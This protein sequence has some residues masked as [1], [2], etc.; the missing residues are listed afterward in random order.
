M[1]AIKGYNLSHGTH[2]PDMKYLS[3][4]QPIETLPAPPMVV[5]SLS[6]SLGKPS[7]PAVEPGYRVLQGQLI[8]S[9]NGDISSNIFSS[10]S[11]TINSIKEISNET[12]GKETFIFIENDGKDEKDFLPPLFNP[13]P[14]DI[15][16]RIKDAGIVGLG[17][18]SFPTAVKTNPKGQVDTLILN[19]AEC[20]PYL[21]CDYRLMLEKT[22]DIVRG[23][24]YIAKALGIANIMTGIEINK[25]DCIAAFEKYN[26]IQPVSLK[27]QYP[28]GSEKHLIYAC[29]KRKVPPGKLPA[30]VGCIVINVAT[31]FA[32]QEAVEFGKPLFE[33]VVTVSG[34]AVNTPK[35]LLVRLGT[36]YDTIITACGGVKNSVVKIVRGGPMTGAALVSNNGYTRK[37]TGG[38]IY[39]DKTETGMF[40][41]QP[42]LSCGKCADACPMRLM[43]MQTSIY[44]EAG[45]FDRAAKLGGVLNCIE[46]GCCSYVCP[47]RRALLQ[48]IRKAKIEL[49]KTKIN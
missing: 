10:V 9:A 33:R 28:V 38:L 46:C 2:V 34:K 4:K 36:D 11:G 31:C 12:G 3:E 13:F 40:E 25:P 7:I 44:A 16:E 19:G 14:C 48:D 37:A 8:A 22:D 17:G 5:I 41:P 6:Q 47:A 39:M 29:K 18:A 42:C 23:A 24:R 21:T 27:R 15:Q 49:R 35:N 32:V 43:P 1:K 26:D 30:D 20:E 45:D